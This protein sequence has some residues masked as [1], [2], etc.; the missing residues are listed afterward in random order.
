[1]QELM[2]KH[3]GSLAEYMR[4]GRHLCPESPTGSHYW[5]LGESNHIP[6]TPANC[7]VC[8]HCREVRKARAAAG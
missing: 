5:A 8:Q 6:K 4:L 3:Q 7:W 1:M 2:V